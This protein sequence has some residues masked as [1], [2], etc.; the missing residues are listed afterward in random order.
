MRTDDLRTL[1]KNQ[2]IEAD[3]CIV[4]SGPAGL[5]IARELAGLAVQVVILESGG[6]VRESD[7][8]ALNEVE[9]VGTER[10]R[11]QWLVR[12][13][14]LG[15]SSHT[16][17]GRCAPF[18]EID[19]E[20]REWVPY[21][22]WPITSRD[23]RPFLARTNS[24]LGLSSG[25]GFTGRE[26]WTIIGRP[27]SQQ[28]LDQELLQPF[29]WQFSKDT[30]DP[31]D[32]MRF[33]PRAIMELNAPNLRAIAHATVTHINTNPDGTA[34]E[35]L[36]VASLCGGRWT[37]RAGT[38]VLCAGGIEN[39]R[40]LLTSNRK[41][42]SGVGN[43]YD[44][45]GRFLM[46]HP[47]STLATFDPKAAMDVRNRFGHYWLKTA[48]GVQRVMHGLTLSPAIQ[49]KEGLLNCAVW[50]NEVT[51]ADNPWCALRRLRRR[52]GNVVRDVGALA[53]H[54]GLLAAGVGRRMRERTFVA[55]RGLL[56]KL[57]RLEL[58]SFVE[59]QPDPDSRITLGDRLDRLGMRV[60][61]ADWRI[62]DQ[63]RRTM[64]RIAQ[65]VDQEFRRVGMTPPTLE[66]CMTEG[67]TPIT[68]C[69]S[70]H[71]TGTTRM[72][73]DPRLGVVDAD[74]QVHGVSGLFVSGSS[75]FPTSGHA[76]PTHM[77]V[78]MAIRLADTLKSRVSADM[79]SSF[80]TISDRAPQHI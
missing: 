33:G 74:C 19:F 64:R 77:I 49:K 43:R 62:G 36:E 8:D 34:V 22:G 76:N 50:L 54:M 75:V 72:S 39:A 4:G 55:R 61:R 3:I 38:V 69:D 52:E 70:A 16:W 17:K 14:I 35:S 46:D 20:R 18:D 44:V 24:H 78:A 79:S 1:P 9:S 37:V 53:S 5:T 27:G 66:D 57:D 13:R 15:G 63:E 41:I 30:R 32:F 59:Q 68:M 56:H 71:P 45:V 65:L 47:R 11:E 25:T 67:R 80:R 42:P 12:N 40:L 26:L 7:T 73:Q 51:T 60:A 10:V 28:V 6:L 2:V 23:L 58:Y 31:R 48:S 29:F 21:S